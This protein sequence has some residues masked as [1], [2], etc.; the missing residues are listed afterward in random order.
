LQGI[1]V[2]LIRFNHCSKLSTHDTELPS[3][4]ADS[5]YSDHGFGARQK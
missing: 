3:V 2:N 1:P 5:G 4:Y